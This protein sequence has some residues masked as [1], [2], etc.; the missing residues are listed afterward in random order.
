MLQLQPAQEIKLPACWE[1]TAKPVTVPS[2]R[3]VGK[4]LQECAVERAST[5]HKPLV[6]FLLEIRFCVM[7]SQG[8]PCFAGQRNPGLTQQMMEKAQNSGHRQAL[9]SKV[10]ASHLAVHWG[11]VF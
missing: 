8:F 9:S 5:T 3:T 6:F 11:R 7:H 1:Q 10:P 2:V 4:L